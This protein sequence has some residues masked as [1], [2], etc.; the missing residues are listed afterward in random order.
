MAVVNS[1]QNSAPVAPSEHVVE[2]SKG[3]QGGSLTQGT[4]MSMW[5]ARAVKLCSGV[6][7]V[8]LPVAALV[9]AAWVYYLLLD[10][11]VV[12]V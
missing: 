3:Q 11:G 1:L 10:A 4:S 7:R 12:A 9:S 2:G 6:V 8:G 5:A